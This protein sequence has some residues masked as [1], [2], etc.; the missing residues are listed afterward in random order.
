MKQT[1][2]LAGIAIA[3][4]ACS[5]HAQPSA[6]A[7]AASAAL[8]AA[9]NG[10]LQDPEKESAGRLTAQGW[11]VLLDRRDWGVAWDNS[12]NLF[13]R[14]VP[15]GNWMDAIPKVRE[16]FGVLVDRQVLETVYKN[17]LAGH[18]PGDY[19]TVIF[20]SKFDKKPDVQE[21]VTT[22]REPDGRW[23]VTGYEPR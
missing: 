1:F 8:P 16:P 13:R 15:L 21:K 17:T 23:R 18:P 3:L 6:P 5:L 12:S 22:M 14:N 19:V 4:M 9:G 11:L 7:T 2:R 10:A 20:Q